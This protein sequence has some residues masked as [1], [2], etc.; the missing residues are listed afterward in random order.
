MSGRTTKPSGSPVARL[1][2]ETAK[3][4]AE[5]KGG[6]RPRTRSRMAAVQALYQMDLAGTDVSAVIEDFILTRFVAVV[7]DDNVPTDADT[8]DVQDTLIGSDAQFFAELLR[9]VVRRQRDI[10][11]LV[12]DQLVEG[13][14]LARVDSIMRAILRSGTF[15][16]MERADVPGRVTINEYVDVAK[17]FFNDDEPKVVNGVLDRLARRLR[18]EEFKVRG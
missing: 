13:W 3:P 18:P 7:T 9:G 10:D 8:Q 5:P 6:P 12:D 14:R 17:A 4:P 16:L 2:G 11:P 1:L 15:E